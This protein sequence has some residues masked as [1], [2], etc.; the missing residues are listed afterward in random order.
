M[1]K[2]VG[3]YSGRVVDSGNDSLWR[4]CYQT[5]SCKNN[6]CIVIISA[7]QVCKQP[8]RTRNKIGTLTATA[9]QTSMLEMEHRQEKPR[10]AFITDLNKFIAS[11][12]AA[13]N[14]VLLIG[15]FNEVLYG[16]NSGMRKLQ[17]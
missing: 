12:H 16:P 10:S 8:I 5:L 1:I 4:W 9:Q 2:T 6:R 15:D 17:E 7:Y 3:N 11:I 14:G 13:G